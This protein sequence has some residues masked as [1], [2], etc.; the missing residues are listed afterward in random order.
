M[1]HSLYLESRTY[2]VNVYDATGSELCSMVGLQFQEVLG[3]PPAEIETRYDILLQPIIASWP[4]PRLPADDFT[5]REVQDEMY[6]YLDYL[7]QEVIRGSLVKEPVI[8]E[9]VLQRCTSFSD[10][11]SDDCV[12]SIAEDTLTL[13]GKPLKEPSRPHHLRTGFRN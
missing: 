6:N 12:R 5:S 13:L 11:A 3:A 1:I 9:E 10:G 7:A 4:V 8:G 2:N